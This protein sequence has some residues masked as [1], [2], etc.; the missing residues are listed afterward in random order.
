MR[1]A[2]LSAHLFASRRQWPNL[3]GEAALRLHKVGK[4]ICITSETILITPQ[5]DFHTKYNHYLDAE[6]Y[7]I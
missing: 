6:S 7:K 2:R 3:T 4:L 5:V 1:I